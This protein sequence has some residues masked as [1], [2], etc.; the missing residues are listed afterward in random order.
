MKAVVAAFNQEKALVGAFS[1]ITNLRMELFQALF[2]IALGSIITRCIVG[3]CVAGGLASRKQS[4]M[5]AEE[6]ETAI[7]LWATVLL[8]HTGRS[9]QWGVIINKSENRKQEP[10]I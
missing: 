10:Y 5:E 6:A 2:L 1:V 8:S 4:T 7:L 9:A 3:T